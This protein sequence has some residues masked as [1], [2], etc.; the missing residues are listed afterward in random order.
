LD[1]GLSLLGVISPVP[2]TG[3]AL[4]AVRAAEHVAEG[5]R[6][7][8]HAADGAKGAV[9]GAEVAKSEAAFFRGAKPGE[10]P[11]FAPKQG[12]FRVDPK[13][14]FV[15]DTHGVSVFDN[16]SSVSSK[17]LTPRRVDQSS[18]PDSLRFIQRGKDPH[19]FEIVPKP[20]AN[21]TPQQFT[22]ACSSIVCV[23]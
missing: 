22:H 8:A 18:V 7:A 15:K 13:T 4:K 1:A 20:G 19:H 5:V 3:E 12:D 14:G 16:S 17:G 10:A 6:A 21:L 2:G 23:R 11:S 9:Q